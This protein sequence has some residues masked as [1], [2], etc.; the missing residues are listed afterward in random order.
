MP[1]ELPLFALLPVVALAGWLEAIRRITR[2]IRVTEN[3]TV[4]GPR[5]RRNRAS[6]V[7][8]LAQVTAANR[9]PVGFY[10]RDSNLRV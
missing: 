9:C 7:D 3:S 6:C 5:N 2:G 10:T 4:V 1:Q 8:I